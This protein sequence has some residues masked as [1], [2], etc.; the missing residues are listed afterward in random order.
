MRQDLTT[1]FTDRQYMLSEDYELYYYHDRHFTPTKPHY[2]SY[3]EFYFFINGD[4]DFIIHGENHPLEQNDIVIIPPGINHFAISND[5]E[6]PYQRIV[7]WIS[8]EY[9]KYFQTIS[10]DFNYI[11]DLAKDHVYVH[12]PDTI[13]FNSFQTK[14]LDIIQE[15][16][17]NHYGKGT[18]INLQVADLLISINR[19]F[20]EKA[21][22]TEVVP[23]ASLYN[24]LIDYI[25]SNIT[26]PI[27][28]D[29]LSKTFYTSKSYISH[30]FKE[31][32]GISLH[33]YIIKR[34]L[35]LFRDTVLSSEDIKSTYQ[36]CGFSDYSCLYKAFKKE[37]GIS[38]NEYKTELIKSTIKPFTG[39]ND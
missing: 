37:Y 24:R 13:A 27:T 4:I 18:K 3:Y 5:A 32:Q 30:I 39:E 14:L 7:F 23:S 34:R 12:H 2:H 20:Y 9:F 38:P 31:N 8:P 21:H 35:Q 16:K 28:L 29:D 10:S 22:P 26:N 11:F 36:N 1:T 25:E 33:Q 6:K 19:H 17:L 15:T